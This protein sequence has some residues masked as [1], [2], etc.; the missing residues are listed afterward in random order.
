MPVIEIDDEV[1]AYLQ[2][3]AV[4]FVE[5]TPNPVL[6][7]LLG[8]APILSSDPTVADQPSTDIVA[9]TRSVTRDQLMSQ[10]RY[11]EAI[12]VAL[13]E[14]NGR[15]RTKEV[16]QIVGEILQD[17][18]TPADLVQYKSG[19]IRWRA[20]ASSEAL[21]LQKKGLLKKDSE[22]GWWELTE[23]G[24]NQAQAIKTVS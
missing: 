18:H 17:E 8:L 15:A 4:A 22:Y 6:R 13:N 20:R 24:E 16:L 9:G 3:Q 2:G 1:F 23:N 10:E 7:R 21:V 12:L 14:I 5:T 19:G 11:Q